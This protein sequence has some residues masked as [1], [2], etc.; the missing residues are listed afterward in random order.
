MIPTATCNQST[1]S[2]CGSPT[3]ISTGHLVAPAALAVNG[4]TLYVGNGDG[5]V[6]VYNA[7]TNQF[8]TTLSLLSG[9]TPTALAVD[10]TNGFVYV[11]DGAN[12]RVEYFNASTCNAT[13]T[14]G[15][16]S[17]P[18]A[19]TVGGDPVGLAVDSVVG[20]LYV[21]NTGAAGGIPVDQLEQP[22]TALDHFDQPATIWDGRGPVDRPVSGRQR[23]PRR[24]QRPAIPG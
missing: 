7:T 1:T 18:L 4:N 12:G 19:V 15:C 14:S 24:P 8:V 10:T 5:T 16:A 3:Q 11:A 6:A 20:D 23:G 22:H 13:T 21:A 2:G 17:V 9:S